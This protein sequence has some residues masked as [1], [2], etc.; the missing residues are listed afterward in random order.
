MTVTRI[1]PSIKCLFLLFL[2]PVVLAGCGRSGQ[3]A[4]AV[5]ELFV[6]RDFDPMVNWN[7]EATLRVDLTNAIAQGFI[8]P[9]LKQTDDGYFDF[10]FSVKNRGN[11]P[12]KFSYKV[13][14]QNES[15]KFPERAQ[16]DTTK[17]H[18]DCWENFYGSWEDVN[19]TFAETGIIPADND[20]HKVNGKIRIV[21]NPRGEQRYFSGTVN[22]RWKRN[23]RV[24][25]YSFM[26]V[27]TT[28]ENI[29]S[30]KIPAAVQ[31]IGL[32]TPTGFIN[33]Y[34]YFLYGEGRGLRNT[35]VQRSPKPLKVMVD[36]D[37]GAGIYINP[38]HF[39]KATADKYKTDLCGQDSVLYRG[40]AF[41]QFMHY[42]DPAT[43]MNNIPAIEDILGSD[44]S[45]LDYNWNKAVLREGGACGHH[46]HRGQTSLRIGSLRPGEPQD[47]HPQ[48]E[49][50]VWKLA[51][52]ECWGDYPPRHD[53]R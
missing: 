42:I 24:G 44:Y 26:L 37:P 36:A 10:S 16:M 11:A 40:A 5:S 53:L 19:N 48:P 12:Q 23:P 15:Y 46:L 22:D 52:A 31:N 38:V 20:F 50:G 43:K 18:P 2:L 29:R 45:R 3:S 51:K 1:N 21:G 25:D 47:H 28:E 7:E 32:L 14:Y 4:E 39:D 27:V 30:G 6:V 8:I 41:E 13:Y 35:I 34:F 17:Q 9:T 49:I 33:P